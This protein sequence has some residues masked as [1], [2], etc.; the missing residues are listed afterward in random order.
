MDYDFQSACDQLRGTLSGARMGALGGKDPPMGYDFLRIDQVVERFLHSF[1][2]FE[3]YRE[4]LL[5]KLRM[6]HPSEQMDVPKACQ[7]AN[8]S[9]R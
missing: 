5:A 2:K 6:E 7:L 4:K 8:T 3:E 9:D 1:P